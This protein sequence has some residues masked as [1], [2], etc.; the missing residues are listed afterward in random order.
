MQ[1]NAGVGDPCDECLRL[2]TDRIRDEMKFGLQ[3]P[4][5]LLNVLSARLFHVAVLIFIAADRDVDGNRKTRQA[6]VPSPE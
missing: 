2:D 6:R 1:D 4:K 3:N 5:R